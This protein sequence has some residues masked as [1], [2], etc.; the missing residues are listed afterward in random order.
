MTNNT[1]LAQYDAPPADGLQRFWISIQTWAE[2]L[3]EDAPF[4]FW[5]SGSGCIYRLRP[6]VAGTRKAEGLPEQTD[7]FRRNITGRHALD[8]E[9]DPD[10]IDRFYISQASLCMLIDAADEDAAIDLVRQH[11]PDATLRFAD[12]APDKTLVTLDENGR[13]CRPEPYEESSHV[14]Q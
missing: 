6:S 9:K 1:L 14:P 5:L 8:F 4:F 3:P 13:F 2:E 11:F 12:P 10:L 7:I